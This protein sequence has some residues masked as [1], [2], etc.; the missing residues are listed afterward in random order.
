[1]VDDVNDIIICDVLKYILNIY[2]NFYFFLICNIKDLQLCPF[3]ISSCPLG[4]NCM[5]QNFIHMIT[6]FVS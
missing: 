1:V 3:L 2:L 5:L 6:D 4:F